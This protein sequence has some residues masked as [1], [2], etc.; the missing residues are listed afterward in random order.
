MDDVSSVNT[1]IGVMADVALDIAEAALIAQY[2][3][4]G[5][6]GIKQVWEFLFVSLK[7]KLIKHLESG[8]D[9]FI[10]AVNNDMQAKAAE[11]AV[12]KLKQVQTNPNATPAQKQY[13]VDDFKSKYRDLI[14]WRMDSNP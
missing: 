1:A 6:W 3:V 14:R 11:E 2:P 12:L 9:V 7:V 10:I 13:A 5:I 4:L 8:V